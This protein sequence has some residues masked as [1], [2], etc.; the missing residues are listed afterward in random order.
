MDVDV[1]RSREAAPTL[2]LGDRMGDLRHKLSSSVM[3]MAMVR[4]C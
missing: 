4:N 3:A 2:P 1:Q